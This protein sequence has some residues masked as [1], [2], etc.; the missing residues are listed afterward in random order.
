VPHGDAVA[1]GMVVEATIAV[2]LGLAD[3]GL[4]DAITTVCDAAGLPVRVPD[5]VAPAEI[6]TGT[7]TDKKTRGGVVEYALPSGLGAMAG[8]D[9]AY[10]IAVPESVVLE[11]LQ[12]L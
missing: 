10:G 6:V 7:R 5:G 9:S 12:S 4:V 8:A 11:T 1:I 2:R 3:A